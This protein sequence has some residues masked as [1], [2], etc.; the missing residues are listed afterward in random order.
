[1]QMGLFMKIAF[2]KCKLIL[3]SAAAQY[4]TNSE[5]TQA[6]HQDLAA[7]M[8]FES[9]MEALEQTTNKVNIPIRG[10]F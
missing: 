9:F 2:L 6:V 8:V 1:M 3:T 7:F 4:L 10:P 5:E